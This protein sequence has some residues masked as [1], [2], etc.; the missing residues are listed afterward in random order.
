MC[1]SEGTKPPA[2]D[3]APHEDVRVSMDVVTLDEDGITIW[4]DDG[5]F[6]PHDVDILT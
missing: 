4:R 5:A 6:S 1:H 2:L 3:I